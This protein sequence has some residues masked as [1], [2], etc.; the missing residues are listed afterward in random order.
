[1]AYLYGGGIGILT[2]SILFNK[3]II[4]VDRCNF[5]NNVAR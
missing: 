2:E 3:F 5:T 1:M 4:T